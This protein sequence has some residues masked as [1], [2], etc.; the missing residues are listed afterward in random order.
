MSAKLWEAT[1]F[2]NYQTSLVT[3]IVNANASII[4]LP[5]GAS[6]LIAPGII[7]VDQFNQSGAL[8]TTLREY[9]SFTTV[10]NGQDQISGLTRG[11][12]GSTGQA[13]TIGALIEGTTTQKHWEDMV[14]FLQ[15]EHTSTGGHVISTATIAYTEA[16]DMAITS[17]AS[18]AYLDISTRLHAS[19]VSL[20]GISD[21]KITIKFNLTGSISGATT[22]LQTPVI[23]PRSGTWDWVNIITQT[24]A[25][26]AS[27]I[28]DINKNGTS[29]FASGT[30]PKIVGAGT[31]VSTASILTTSFSEGDQF[32]WDYDGPSN[33]GGLIT[34]FTI[35]IH[36]T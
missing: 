33:V 27:V 14:D 18:V 2:N 11:L 16:K 12:S 31:F 22:S 29:I 21:N 19:G 24:V 17:L 35:L 23:T 4:Y 32:N 6:G 10:T 8:T 30:R 1:A 34:N 5:S 13:H 20:L 9:I 15:V 26:G 28:F 7:T 25:S 36:S 3:G